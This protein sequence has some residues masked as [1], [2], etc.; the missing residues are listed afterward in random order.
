ML[1]CG[2]EINQTNVKYVVLKSSRKGCVVTGHGRVELEEN[3]SPIKVMARLREERQIPNRV[4][5]ASGIDMSQLRALTLPPMP[6]REMELA[7]QHEINRELE[8]MD[9]EMASGYQVL[10]R[11]ASGRH[12]LLVAQT[13]RRSIERLEIDLAAESFQIEALTTSSIALLSYGITEFGASGEESAMAV[14]HIGDHRMLLAVLDHGHI[15]LIRDLGLGLDTSLFE[16]VEVEATGTD[17]PVEADDGIDWDGL[18]S[19]SRGLS[20][21]N[22]VAGQIRRTLEYDGQQSP[23]TPVTRVLLA[24]DVTRAEAMAP[25]ISNEITLPVELLD[26]SGEFG[27]V[28]EPDFSGEGP[29]YALPFAL[30]KPRRAGALLHLGQLPRA[31]SRD[32]LFPMALVSVI[33]GLLVTIC[34]LSLTEDVQRLRNLRADLDGEFS[35]LE[36]R[37]GLDEEG[38]DF[39]S[40][41]EALRSLFENSSPIEVLSWTAS[42]IPERENVE[43]L[44]F[45]RT[46]TTWQA[47]LNGAFRRSNRESQAS[48]WSRLLQ[49]LEREPRVSSLSIPAVDGASQ[50][51]NIPVSFEF[52]WESLQ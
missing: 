24:G 13:P 8:L 16:T 45:S 10:G 50:S 6:K 51:L 44:T 39:G 42:R 22:Q 47:G 2:V 52:T 48:D 41:P 7:I 33:L 21:I 40:Q 34:S 18:E 4:R 38:G 12:R 11:E 49:S 3:Q 37:L 19:L 36:A 32:P 1:T 46:G 29:S 20:E 17:G 26:P 35:A 15:R 25:L 14:L 43:K 27:V 30:A 5:V 23:D 28:G 31:K 9:E